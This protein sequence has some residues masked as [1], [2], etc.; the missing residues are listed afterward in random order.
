MYLFQSFSEFVKKEMKKSRDSMKTL[1]FFDISE[2]LFYSLYLCI[3]ET[4]IPIMCLSHLQ[5][6]LTLYLLNEGIE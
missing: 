3:K 5:K 4:N 2:V 1:S 6:H